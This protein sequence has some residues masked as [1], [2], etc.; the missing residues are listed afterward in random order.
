MT[1]KPTFSLHNVVF[2]PLYAFEGLA[3]SLASLLGLG[4]IGLA[5]KVAWGTPVLLTLVVL[6]GLR[7]VRGAHLSPRLW[8]VAT[9]TAVYWFLAAFNYIPGREAYTSRYMYAGAALLLL[10]AAELARG[11]RFGRTALLAGVAV[12]AAA[13]V[14]NLAPLSDG[15]DWLREQ[16]VLT[17][18]DLAGIEIAHRS[19]EPGFSLTPEVAGTPSLVDVDAGDYLA[20]VA[21]H[22]SPAYT[23][24]ELLAAPPAGRRQADVVLAQALPVTTRSRAGGIRGTTR[25]CVVVVASGPGQPEIRL[26]PGLTGIAVAPGEPAGLTLRRFAFDEYPIVLAGGRGGT[27]TFLRIPRDAAPQPWFLHVEA[28]QPVRVCR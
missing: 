26:D 1:P 21:D 10:L 25:G 20:M 9:A 8:P 7:L 27:T 5:G 24:A 16:T 15:K 12:G 13:V 18:A 3:A 22:G 23:P 11:V 17:R 14:L 28:M 4:T 2:S 19:V 6:L